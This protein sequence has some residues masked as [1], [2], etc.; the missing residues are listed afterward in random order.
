MAV[1][2]IYLLNK[3]FDKKALHLPSLTAA[4]KEWYS[5]QNLSSTFN[6]AL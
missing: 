6:P 4:L 2:Y 5:L 3:G 1:M